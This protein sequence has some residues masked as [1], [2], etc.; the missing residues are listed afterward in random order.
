PSRNGRVCEAG[1]CGARKR[2]ARPRGRERCAEL[3][4]LTAAR[5]RGRCALRAGSSRD[6]GLQPHAGPGR[7]A[8]VAAGRQNGDHRPQRRA[9][10]RRAWRESAVII[11]RGG[12]RSGGRRDRCCDSRPASTRVCGWARRRGRIARTPLCGRVRT[13]PTWGET[14]M[15]IVAQLPSRV[16][17]TGCATG[18]GEA[19]AHM[20][21]EA[22]CRLAL[23]DNQETRLLQLARKLDAFAVP[24]DVSDHEALARAV[25]QAIDGLGGLDA[26][27]SNAGVQQG[28]DVEEASVADFDYSY[29]VNVRAHFI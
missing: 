14:F 29:M 5:R 3:Q 7:V 9:W 26:A 24:V 13:G 21:A 10:S 1:T 27:W 18:I 25:D 28:G 23:L 11:A 17:V 22:G 6:A 19:G 12:G 15:S 8:G 4:R 16:L 20:L 2:A